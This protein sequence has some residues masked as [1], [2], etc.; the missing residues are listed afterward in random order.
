MKTTQ[1]ITSIILNSSSW[2]L[3]GNAFIE[4]A[5]IGIPLAE[6]K[7]SSKQRYEYYKR[8]NGCFVYYMTS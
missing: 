2:A 7:G 6:N 8:E 3:K 1:E 4:G 5:T